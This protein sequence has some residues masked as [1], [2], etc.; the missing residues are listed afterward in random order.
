[1][2]T[3]RRLDAAGFRDATRAA[4]RFAEPALDGATRRRL[5]DVFGRELSADDAVREIVADVRERGDVALRE[6]TLRIDG[7]AVDTLHADPAGFEP[8]WRALP[9]ELREALELARARILAFHEMQGGAVAKG[10]ADLH[11]RPMPV[12]RAGCYVPGGRAAYPSTVLMNVIPAQVAGVGSIV[13]VT[14]PGPDGRAHPAVLAAAHLLGVTEVAVAGGA[15]AIAA[16]AYGTASLRPVDVIVGPGNLFVTL[17]KRAVLGAVGIDGLAGPSEILVVASGDAQ[18]DWIAADL[19]SQLEHD[20]LAWA[21][22]LT[23]SA[24]LA[25]AVA[26]AFAEPAAGAKRAGIVEEAAG[27]HGCL[28]V[29]ASLDEALQLTNEFAPEHLE[30][31]GFDAEPLLDGV[32]AAGAV[33]VG[34]LTPVP[35]GDYIAGP[36][37]TLP[38][39]GAARFRGPLSVMD[40]VRWMSVTRLDAQDM[41]EL[42]P[43][44]RVLAD[45]EGLYGHSASVGLRLDALDSLD[46]LGA[47]GGDSL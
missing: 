41:L 8:A 40:F 18:P 37:H 23:D 12:G 19:V 15:Q 29:C 30:L 47:R 4:R 31:I 13:V 43:T 28:V 36:N 22:C 26:A 45:A 16:L 21:V 46:Q 2:A 3:L 44:V 32:R 38:T 24:R 34:G 5:S 33:F 35:M 42:G 7:V 25:D 11:L 1:M 14:P 9:D 39:G 6:W 20:P 17:A 27:R 10:P